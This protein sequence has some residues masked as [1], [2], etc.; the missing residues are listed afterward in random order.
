ML[1]A[2]A[3]SRQS[4]KRHGVTE[5]R[6]CC[7]PQRPLSRCQHQVWKH[8]K[9]T[10]DELTAT[11]NIVKADES[12][13]QGLLFGGDEAEVEEEEEEEDKGEEEEDEL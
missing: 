2:S 11:M 8:V 1:R 13:V 9:C 3:A 4:S 7:C 5:W 10:L 6:R 12:H